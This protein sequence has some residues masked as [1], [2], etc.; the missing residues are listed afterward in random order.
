MKIKYFTLNNFAITEK[1]NNLPESKEY[2]SYR[3]SQVFL[4]SITTGK[5]SLKNLIFRNY[6]KSKQPLCAKRIFVVQVIG[7]SLNRFL[8]TIKYFKSWKDIF[9]VTQKT[10]LLASKEF[11]RSRLSH[12]PKIDLHLRGNFFLKNNWSFLRYL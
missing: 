9:A 10:N 1:L 5:I 7:L 6:W 11:L 12:R 2:L 8:I 3:L 4:K